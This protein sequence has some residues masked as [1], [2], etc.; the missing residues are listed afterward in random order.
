MIRFNDIYFHLMVIISMTVPYLY[1]VSYT[2]IFSML[3]SKLPLSRGIFLFLQ[4]IIKQHLV[5][6]IIVKIHYISIFNII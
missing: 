3:T 5:N 4:G 6:F 1:Q 2:L